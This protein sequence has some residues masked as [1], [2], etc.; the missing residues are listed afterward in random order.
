MKKK[1]FVTVVNEDYRKYMGQLIKSHKLFCNFDLI[2]YTINFDLSDIKLEKVIFKE[3]FDKN[4][5]EYENLSSNDIIK[6]QYE[7]HK[8]T[9]LLKPL[10][11]KESLI[12][13]YDD[14]LFID[15]DGLLTKNSDIFFSNIVNYIGEYNFP[16]ST[17]YFHQ[18]STGHGTNELAFTQ[19]GGYNIKSAGYY[20][21]I[22]LYNTEYHIIDYLTTYCILYNRSCINFI[23]EVI[24]ICFDPNVISDYKKYLPMGDETVFNYLYSKYNFSKYM[25]SKLCFDVPPYLPINDVQNN[26]EKT[27]NF[28]SYIHTKRHEATN[29]SGKDFSNLKHE[30]YQQIFDILLSK[31]NSNTKISISSIEK[32]DTGEIIYFNLDDDYSGDYKLTIVSLFRPNEEHI[33]TMNLYDNVSFFIFVEKNNDVW[34]KDTHLIIQKEEIIKDIY[35]LI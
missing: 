2:V 23:N 1:C 33:F 29:F 25:S 26:L 27:K 14:F 4:L 3:Y 13:D 20:P 24:D 9:T 22:E 34:V 15:C 35:K 12:E 6:N 32:K 21:L 18:Y 28:V 10:I 17:K 5:W 31:E 19:Y 16:V 7:K 8:Y 30:E 11:L